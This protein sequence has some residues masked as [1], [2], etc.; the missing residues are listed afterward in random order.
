MPPKS[1]AGSLEK[2]EPFGH[3]HWAGKM[4]GSCQYSVFGCKVAKGREEGRTMAEGRMEKKKTHV[5]RGIRVD[6]RKGEWPEGRDAND[7]TEMIL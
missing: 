6:Q 2:M 1:E 3:D 4:G 5:S 7:Q